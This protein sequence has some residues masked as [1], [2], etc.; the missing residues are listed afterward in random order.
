M[1]RVIEVVPWRRQ[2]PVYSEKHS[3]CRC[4]RWPSDVR[5]PGISG[6]GIDIVM[7]ECSGS[8]TTLHWRHNGRGGVSNH[9]SYGC[10]LN[11][12]YRRR[13][14][15]TSK[16]H[17]T[18]L[19]AGNSPV[20]CE[21][22]AQMASN[23]ENVPI[24]W[25]HHEKLLISNSA[26]FTRLVAS[27]HMSIYLQSALTPYH[28]TPVTPAKPTRNR[29]KT[30]NFQWIVQL[31]A[32]DNVAEDTVKPVGLMSG[33]L[34]VRFGMESPDLR[35]IDNRHDTEWKPTISTMLES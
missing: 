18:G 19:C 25:C 31:S 21:F 9:Q 13:S 15:K 26:S 8:S 29:Q 3:C 20:T 14:K 11:R 24:W 7:L 22:R 5:R 34:R 4:H 28:Y 6:H 17:V 10:L 32:T 1:V 2:G 33:S 12:L 16:L 35:P 23:A 30:Q 27:W